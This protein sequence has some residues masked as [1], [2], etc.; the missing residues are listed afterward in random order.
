MRNFVEY[1]KD[2]DIMDL[3]NLLAGI[4]QSGGYELAP[5]VPPI[6][7]QP[8]VPKEILK[9]TVPKMPSAQPQ[10]P[11]DRVVSDPVVAEYFKNKGAAPANSLGEYTDENRKKI[12]DEN[13]GFSMGEGLVAALSA[14]GAGF[15]GRDSGAALG[16][17][18]DRFSKAK[19][20]RIDEFDK[21]RA[22]KIQ[23][24][25]IDQ[26][27]AARDPASRE[28]IAFRKMFEAKFPEVAKSYGD[29]WNEV[30]ASDREALLD[31]LK[32]KENVE[33]RKQAAWLAN[34]GRK[35]ALS[36]RM[37]ERERLRKEKLQEKM[38]QLAVPGYE[39]TGEVLPKAEEAMK[40]RKAT[41]TADAL[42]Q[43]LNRM[44]QLVKDKGSFEYGGDAGTEMES[45]ATEIQLLGKSPELYELGVLTGPDLKLLQKITADPTS[46]DSLFTR[47][48]SRIKQ[49]DT[50]LKSVQD[51]VGTTAKSLGYRKVGD[52]GGG[53]S[54]DKDSA[55]LEWARSNPN[56]PRAAKILQRL[57]M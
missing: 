1:D 57:G 38:D 46:V 25:K 28:S 39:R 56:D 49:I 47:D 52:V 6:S 7:E 36:E 42:G 33:A 44:R 45:L 16:S 13:S 2:S 27:G 37:D 48:S 50:Q 11:I 31:P 41:A 21:T 4:P 32:L 20:G 15:Q 35:D 26:E 24:N 51:K 22:Q 12:V 5:S 43:K 19:Q 17:T 9:K 23:A 54:V 40:F 18:L 34:E 10:D 55:A 3:D 8:I 30:A 29:M 14:L 53:Q